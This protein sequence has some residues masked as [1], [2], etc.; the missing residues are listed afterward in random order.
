MADPNSHSSRPEGAVVALR[1]PART[2][3]AVCLIGAY[4][5]ARKLDRETIERSGIIDL[6][7]LYAEKHANPSARALAADLAAKLTEK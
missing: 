6:L 5:V 1:S 3:I 2:P 7:L 4:N